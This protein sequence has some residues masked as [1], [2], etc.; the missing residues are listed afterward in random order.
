MN[1]L[2][3]YNFKLA[4]PCGLGTSLGAIAEY[5]K[6]YAEYFEELSKDDFVGANDLLESTLN[7]YLDLY[8]NPFTGNSP[9]NDRIWKWCVC[10]SIC[11][12]NQVATG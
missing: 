11:G 10:I 3:K 12:S 5:I 4:L 2:T 6:E 1:A 8:F 7:K 9:I